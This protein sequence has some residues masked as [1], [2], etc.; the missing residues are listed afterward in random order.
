MKI[1]ETNNKKLAVVSPYHPRFVEGARRLN[2]K[3]NAGQWEFDLR[4][5]QRVRKL[6][7][8]VYGTDGS[9]NPELTDVT[10][11]IDARTPN[12]FF[13]YGREVAVRKGRDSRVTLGDGVIV[14]DGK[15]PASCGSSKYPGLLS[16]GTVTLE[17]RDIPVC[18]VTKENKDDQ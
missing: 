11:T 16:N 15:F 18:L 8:E 4:D 13:A 17:V 5:N 12:P 7:V 14:I 2:G 9:D 3:W 6:M 1:F 10:M